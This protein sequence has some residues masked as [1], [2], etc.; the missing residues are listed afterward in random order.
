MTVQVS[1]GM[2]GEFETIILENPRVRAV[3]VPALGGRVWELEDRLRQRQWIWHRPDVPLKAPQ[4]GAVYDDVWSGGW[5]ELFPNDAPG[6]FDDRQLPDHGEWWAM[7]W[8]LMDVTAAAEARVALTANSQIVRASCVKEFHL[9]NDGAT[10]SVTYRIRSAEPQPFYFLFKQHL[11][12][13]IAP[14]CRLRLPG[15]RAK[16]VDPDFSTLLRS[17]SGFDWPEAT[18]AAGVVDM[19]Q[20]LPPSSK[21]KE[22]VYVRDLP[23]AWCGVDDPGA[24]ASIRMT[25]DPSVFP[26]VWL[27]ITYGGWRDLYTVVLEPCSNMPKDLAEAVQAG[28]SALLLPGQEF[29]TTVSVTLSDWSGG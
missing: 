12:V 18:H 15:G 7:A 22:F 3:I 17:G 8:T 6:L 27:F 19:Q 21:R 20:V 10:L 16:P 26:Y 9:A 5:E 1:R 13:A 23:E 14:G 2:A 11:P 24:G 25:F 28:Q 4:V 29:V